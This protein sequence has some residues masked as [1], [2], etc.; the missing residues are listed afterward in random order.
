MSKYL[1]SRISRLESALVLSWL[2]SAL[3]NLTNLPN[4]SDCSKWSKVVISCDLHPLLHFNPLTPLL[5]VPLLSG[6]LSKASK[7][8][9]GTEETDAT[10]TKPGR[11]TDDILVKI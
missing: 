5:R 4:F 6:K 11:C 1:G 2:E 7:N 8:Q 3:T 9:G 10:G